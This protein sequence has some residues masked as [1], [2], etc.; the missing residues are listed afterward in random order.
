ML[1]SCRTAILAIEAKGNELLAKW[2]PISIDPKDAG[3]SLFGGVP[4][5]QAEVPAAGSPAKPCLPACLL[6]RALVLAIHPAW[7]AMGAP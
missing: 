3:G 6:A 7:A 2:F 5:E 1:S 4:G